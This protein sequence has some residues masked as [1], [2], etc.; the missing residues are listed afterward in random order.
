MAL[1]KRADIR[2]TQ[3]SYPLHGPIYHKMEQ[4]EI[5]RRRC[6]PRVLITAFYCF[7]FF[8]LLFYLAPCGVLASA[9]DMDPVYRKCLSSG[10]VQKFYGIEVQMSLSLKLQIAEHCSLAHKVGGFKREGFLGW[11][12]ADECAYH[13]MHWVSE[14]R[15]TGNYSTLKYYGHWPYYRVY[16][17]QEPASAIFSAL[18]A[19]PHLLALLLPRW[20]MQLVRP[21]HYLGPYLTVYSVVA[22]NAWAASSLYHT[23]KLD[24]T[25]QYDYVSAL[26]LVAYALCFVIRRMLGPKANIGIVWAGCSLSVASFLF[27]VYQM[28]ENKVSFGSHM[29]LCV[30]ISVLHAFLWLMWL[31]YTDRDDRCRYMCFICQ[32]WFAVASLLEIFDFEPIWQHFDAHALWHAATVPLGFLWYLFWMLDVNSVDCSCDQSQIS[33][34]AE[35][36]LQLVFPHG[37]KVKNG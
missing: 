11:S 30:T 25:T 17:L 16:G 12:A 35:G 2:D 9:G 13:C 29:K 31:V 19:V 27:Q 36:T 15:R 14:L 18:N 8:F 5:T 33:K 28:I 4:D 6:R 3:D 37:T 26:A 32:A 21:G 22:I 1:N 10:K 23:R 7:R 20:R 24:W 34:A